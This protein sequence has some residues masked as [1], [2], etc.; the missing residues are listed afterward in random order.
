[1]YEE[2]KKEKE[3]TTVVL[4]SVNDVNRLQSKQLNNNIHN[5]LLMYCLTTEQI[6][7]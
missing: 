3:I 7:N 5:F 6:R 1:M 2:G 4:Q